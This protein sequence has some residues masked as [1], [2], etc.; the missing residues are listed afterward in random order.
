MLN[1]GITSYEYKVINSKNITDEELKLL[2]N[3]DKNLERK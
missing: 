3:F 1:F 2:K